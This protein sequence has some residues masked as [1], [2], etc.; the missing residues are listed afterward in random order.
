MGEVSQIFQFSV[1]QIWEFL[2]SSMTL[3]ERNRMI[4]RKESGILPEDWDSHQQELGSKSHPTHL[5]R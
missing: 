1:N 3:R 2:E 4:I 5:K